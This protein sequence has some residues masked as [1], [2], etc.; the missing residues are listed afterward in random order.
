MSLDTLK[1]AICNLRDEVIK[2]TTETIFNP[3]I[4]ETLNKVIIKMNQ[5][6]LKVSQKELMKNE[7]N[8]MEKMKREIR[9]KFLMIT[10]SYGEKIGTIIRNF[11]KFIQDFDYMEKEKTQG[12][13]LSK[14]DFYEKNYSKNGENQEIEN[15]PKI[16]PVF[17]IKNHSNNCYLNSILQCLCRNIDLHQSIEKNSEI[18]SGLFEVPWNKPKKNLIST[19]SDFIKNKKQIKS[20]DKIFKIL[21]NE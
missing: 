12:T 21:K 16:F 2:E 5:F 4:R 14:I 17:G 3:L 9:S 19:L 8:E 6:I 10:Q 7:L 1:T 13:Q 20:Q 15:F 18:K 11:D